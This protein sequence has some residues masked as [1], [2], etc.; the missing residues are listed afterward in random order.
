MIEEKKNL[1]PRIVPDSRLKGDYAAAIIVCFAGLFFV[2]FALPLGASIVAGACVWY[3]HIWRAEQGRLTRVN[4]D[5]QFGDDPADENE[6]HFP[7]CPKCRAEHEEGR[8]F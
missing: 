8:H 1:I 7:F 3:R 4:R 2:G 6:L 5:A